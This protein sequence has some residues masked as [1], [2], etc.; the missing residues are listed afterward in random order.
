MKRRAFFAAIALVAAASVAG[1]AVQ[2][3]K[4]VNLPPAVKATIHAVTQGGATTRPRAAM[5]RPDMI[6][7]A[8]TCVPGSIEGNL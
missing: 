6:D 4:K 8:M 3:K 7:A 5:P 2:E 1:A